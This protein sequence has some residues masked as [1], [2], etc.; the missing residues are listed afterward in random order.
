MSRIRS[1]LQAEDGKA[2]E[3]RFD[4]AVCFELLKQCG[5]SS[6]LDEGLLQCV[7][8]K[9]LLVKAITRQCVYVAKMLRDVQHG[10]WQVKV[11][12]SGA[13][14]PAGF[15]HEAGSTVKSLSS[16]INAGTRTTG[17]GVSAAKLRRCIDSLRSGAWPSSA[18]ASSLQ[19]K[20]SIVGCGVVGS[21]ILKALIASK[22]FH[23][24]S[25]AVSTRQPESL[26]GA[27]GVL[28]CFDNARVVS[29]ADLVFI[30]CL[31]AQF[32]DVITSIRGCV[33]PT[34]VVMSAVLGVSSGRLCQVLNHPLCLTT[35]VDNAV[36]SFAEN[37]TSGI[38]PSLSTL[39]VTVGP[40]AEKKSLAFDNTCCPYTVRPSSFEDVFNLLLRL[41]S[42]SDSETGASIVAF[43]NVALALFHETDAYALLDAMPVLP[44][45]RAAPIDRWGGLS[46][47]DGH[48]GGSLR[49]KAIQK[50]RYMTVGI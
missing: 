45:K 28:A 36:A 22:L 20:V 2:A 27:A 41:A 13:A 50:F 47:L 44:L 5:L 38:G 15:G 4:A 40:G 19:L 43:A 39:P 3:Q 30:C 8:A 24:T 1:L 49:E 11:A 32:P 17:Q 46:A 10:S 23:V 7:A 29:G 6:C 31:P 25:L 34:A 48:V 35:V 14:A 26:V 21:S 37:S 12:P 16:T 18:G 33:K 42:L 9:P